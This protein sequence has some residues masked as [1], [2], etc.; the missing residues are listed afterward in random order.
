MKAP[1][2]PPTMPSRIRRA[3]FSAIVSPFLARDAEDLAVRRLIGARRREIVEGFLGDPDDVRG[4]ERRPFCRPVLGVLDGA[5]P[6][7]NGPARIIVGSE[8]RKDR[9]EVDL[10]VAQRAEAPCPLY[11]ALEAAI[12]ALLAGRIEL[13]VLDV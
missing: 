6:F 5:F 9:G 2:P 4:D 7:E 12:D 11:P 10:P 13:R 1:V 3:P 8:L